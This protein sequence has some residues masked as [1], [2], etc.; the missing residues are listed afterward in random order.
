[1][2]EVERTNV[3]EL[4]SG[5]KHGLG[6]HTSGAKELQ[7]VAVVAAWTSSDGLCGPLGLALQLAAARLFSVSESAVM[8][9]RHSAEHSSLVA[10]DEWLENHEAAL[11]WFLERQQQFTQELLSP[12]SP[13]VAYRGLRVVA[14]ASS[15][16]DPHLR[17]LSSFSATAAAAATFGDPRNFL[18]RCSAEDASA[19]LLVARVPATR[20]LSTSATG[21]S[22][23][24]EG[25]AVVIGPQHGVEDEVWLLR[26]EDG[27]FGDLWNRIDVL[28]G[29]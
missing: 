3:S 7:G 10:A 18:A 14:T 22:S 17:P 12:I 1:L 4:F 15:R 28:S 26:E 20:V 19:C 24:A 11:A 16:H 13:F 25:E 5:T 27:G 21:L 29:G 2:D 9:L 8:A 6:T 23:A